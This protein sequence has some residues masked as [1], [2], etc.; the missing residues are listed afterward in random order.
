MPAIFLLPVCVTYWPRK[1]T[2][3]VD[4]HV[5]NSHQVWSWCDHPLP[6]YYVLSAD[7]SHDFVTL[8]FHLLTLSSC[9]AWRVTW[10]I[11]PPSYKDPMPIRFELWVITFPFGYHWKCVH[12]H[13]ACAESRDPWVWGQT[14]TFL[15]CPTP[16]C[17]F[18]IQ[19]LLG[20]DDLRTPGPSPPVPSAP[21]PGRFLYKRTWSQAF[22]HSV[23]SEKWSQHLAIGLAGC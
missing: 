21:L 6:S 4:P 18:T 11:L 5:D 17:L 20:Y 23:I 19:L 2:T 9:R 22:C 12:G 1:Y 8:T 13:C 10:P 14:I 15:E 3:R 7:T 16:I